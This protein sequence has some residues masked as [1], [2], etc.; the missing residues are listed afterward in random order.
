MKKQTKNTIKMD[1]SSKMALKGSKKP[2][3]T[4]TIKKSNKSAKVPRKNTGNDKILKRV[5]KQE[6]RLSKNNKKYIHRDKDFTV[7]MTDK[8]I[9]VRF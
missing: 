6:K 3:A 1:K 4:S 2:Q 9:F 5:A 7:E 8:G